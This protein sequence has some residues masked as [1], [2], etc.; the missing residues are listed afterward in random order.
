MREASFTCECIVICH[1]TIEVGRTFDVYHHPRICIAAGLAAVATCRRCSGTG[2]ADTIESLTAMM[3]GVDSWD[4]DDVRG[5][6]DHWIIGGAHDR[7]VA[8]L[9]DRTSAPFWCGIRSRVGVV[10]RRER[11]KRFVRE[12]GV[13]TTAKTIPPQVEIA[14]NNGL[15]QNART[16]RECSE[17]LRQLSAD[18]GSAAFDS[19]A[20]ILAMPADATRAAIAERARAEIERLRT[21]SASQFAELS[22]APTDVQFDALDARLDRTAREHETAIDAVRR[23]RALLRGLREQLATVGREI[24]RSHR[25][26]LEMETLAGA[27]HAEEQASALLADV[28]LP[29]G[30]GD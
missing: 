4:A 7:D 26:R 6:F 21:A 5:F 15:T 29:D 13:D 8:A 2:F 24:T 12:N 30:E 28:Q 14:A 20:G 23:A 11:A 10:I 22:A 3:I 9:W 1:D 19:L 27:G 18:C 25:Y 16:L 17:R